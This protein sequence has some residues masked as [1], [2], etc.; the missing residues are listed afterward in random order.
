MAMEAQLVHSPDCL[1]WVAQTE[2][3]NAFNTAKRTAT[4]S[5]AA[6]SA[7]QVGLVGYIARCYEKIPAKAIYEMDSGEHRT[8]ECKSGAQQGDG[9]GPPLFC[10]ALVPI[11]SKLRSKYEPERVRITAYMDDINLNFK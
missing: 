4:V 11:V 3:S 8:I 9:M 6:K 5:E 10:L 7:P 1:L 2:C